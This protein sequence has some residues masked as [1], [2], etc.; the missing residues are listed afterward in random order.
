MI[1]ITA[2]IL[3]I[4][5]TCALYTPSYWKNL[6]KD[7]TDGKFEEKSKVSVTI[8]TVCN[9]V[10]LGAAPY[11]YNGT[12]KSGYLKVGKGNSALSFIFYGREHTSQADLSKYP[13]LI[14]LNGGPGS[15][16]QL[17]NFMELG[18]FWIKPVHMAP[19]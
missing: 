19:Y 13:I 14:W 18:P 7:V 15:S 8:N 3:L 11:G 12:V 17:G 2:L 1:K 6:G 16:S 9:D 5:V 4:G 10:N